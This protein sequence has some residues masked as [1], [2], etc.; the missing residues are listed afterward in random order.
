MKKFFSIVAM[1]VTAV[2]AVAAGAYIAK[3]LE[4]KNDDEVKLIEIINDDDSNK[5][6]DEEEES[7]KELPEDKPSEI[8]VLTLETV[9]E[10]EV[11]LVEEMVEEL[12]LVEEVTEEVEE[13]EVEPVEE[14]AEE[15]E[16]LEVEL[17]EEMVE[18]AEEPEIEVVE[19]MVEEVEEPEI[20]VVEEMVEEVEEPE[21]EVVEEMVEE[22][23]E[24]EI[25]L[26]EEADAYPLISERKKNAICNQIQVMLESMEELEE[27]DLQHYIVFPDVDATE[28]WLAEIE[29]KGYDIF[30][31][32][33]GQEVNLIK[34]SKLDYD[35]LEKEILTLAQVAAEYNGAYK[36]WAAKVDE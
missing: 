31:E 7:N 35:L 21:I 12:E 20:E 10:P 1:T 29:D 22:T 33:N 28:E 13:P 36:G 2:T 4:S 8:E 18:E 24:P 5:E 23:E 15:V 34:N 16:E 9:N 14:V 30:V 6:L 32:D 25:E 26:V 3:K 27:V 19:E 11:E 17:V